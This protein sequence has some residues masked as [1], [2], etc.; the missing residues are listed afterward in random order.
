MKKTLLILM[1]LALMLSA[2]ALGEGE[3]LPLFDP[4]AYEYLEMPVPLEQSI[5]GDWYAD[6]LGL[7]MKLTLD[8]GAYKLEF[9]G[10]GKGSSGAWEIKD[11]MLYL[12]GNDAPLLPLDTALIWSAVSLTFLREQPVTYVPAEV[13]AGAQAELFNGFWRAH[14]T[15]VGGARDTSKRPAVR[16]VQAGGSVILSSAI[17]DDTALYIEN[18]KAALAGQ[19]FG[20]QIAEFSLKDGAPTAKVD[21]AKVTLQ[22]QQ[23]GILRLTYEKGSEAKVIYLMPVSDPYA[24]QD[25]SPVAAAYEIGDTVLF[26]RYEQDNVASNGKEPIEWIIMDK[27]DDGSYLLMSRYALDCMQ[28]KYEGALTNWEDSLLRLWLNDEFYKSAFTEGEQAMIVL[29]NVPADNG[30]KNGFDAG[31]DTMDKVFV[32]GWSE[33]MKY[34]IDTSW[35]LCAPTAFAVANGTP[36]LEDVKIDGIAACWYWLRSIDAKRFAYVNPGAHP[37]TDIFGVRPVMWVFLEP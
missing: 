27:K 19:L 35:E 14:F 16:S 33:S 10:T 36:Q 8:E 3:T 15:Q 18:G 29:S 21:S 9:P 30:G 32:F 20:R 37:D 5:L 13:Y 34:L 31:A 1:T 25:Y 26:G 4:D 6:F 2:F 24:K 17:G 28:Y 11:G 7:T 12:E 23:D 22:L